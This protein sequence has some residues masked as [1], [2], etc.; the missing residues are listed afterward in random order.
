MLLPSLFGKLI[1]CDFTAHCRYC[2]EKL[3]FVAPALM[4][5]F[6]IKPVVVKIVHT[7]RWFWSLTGDCSFSS[8]V[9]FTGYV[10]SALPMSGNEPFAGEPLNTCSYGDSGKSTP[11]DGSGWAQAAAESRSAAASKRIGWSTK[12]TAVRR[13]PA[14]TRRRSLAARLARPSRP[15]TRQSRQVKLLA[16]IGALVGS[17][18]HRSR[19]TEAPSCVRPGRAA[20]V[21]REL[22]A[23]EIA[24]ARRDGHASPRRRRDAG[25]GAPRVCERQPLE[26]RRRAGLFLALRGRLAR[27]SEAGE[28]LGARR[29]RLLGELVLAAAAG[30]LVLVLALDSGGF[31][32]RGHGRVLCGASGGF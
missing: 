1:S 4:Y 22:S 10:A 8:S 13:K 6:S 7:P 24:A 32:V 29:R 5:R 2:S 9:D 28:E 21:R 16:G 31:G 15:P 25:P 23:D 17:R 27:L 26:C 11:P 20:A 3:G 30:L 18:R 19:G 12:Q 14:E